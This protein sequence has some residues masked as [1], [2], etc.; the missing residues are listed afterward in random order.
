MVIVFNLIIKLIPSELNN[1]FEL[2]TFLNYNI[3]ILYAQ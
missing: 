3:N 2:F 1:L